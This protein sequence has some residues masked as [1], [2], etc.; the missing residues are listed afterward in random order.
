MSPTPRTRT[1][2][3]TRTI[4]PTTPG[5]PPS[6]APRW[7]GYGGDELRVRTWLWVAFGIG[8]SAQKETSK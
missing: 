2:G 5:W 4:L 3:Y 7:P 6:T 8:V 1:D